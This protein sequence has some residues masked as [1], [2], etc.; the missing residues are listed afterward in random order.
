M[1]ETTDPPTR[2]PNRGDREVVDPLADHTRMLGR[3]SPIHRSDSA[4]V[5]RDYQPHHGGPELVTSW[6]L[7]APPTQTSIG[8]EPWEITSNED[9]TLQKT[10]L[11]PPYLTDPHFAPAYLVVCG[12][13]HVGA[14]GDVLHLSLSNTSLSGKP[15]ETEITL[16]NTAPAPFMTPLVE[17]TPDRAD[18]EHK[19]WG[20]SP[21]MYVLSACVSGTVAYLDAGTNV[22]LWSE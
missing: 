20:S 12:Q 4:L 3:R 10:I 18:Y 17:V 1:T 21:T 14:D 15:Y 22:Q 7:G 2:T 13:G 6:A 19:A 11:S 5:S 16:T 8:D 9:V